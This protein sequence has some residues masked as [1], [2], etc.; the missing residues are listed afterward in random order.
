MQSTVEQKVAAVAAY[1]VAC[2]D[3]TK[4]ARA[5]CESIATKALLSSN[6][7]VVLPETI[8]EIVHVLHPY[9]LIDFPDV[10]C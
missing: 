4:L 3:I 6:K 8:I 10:L 2:V 7:D 5:L 9:V 1:V